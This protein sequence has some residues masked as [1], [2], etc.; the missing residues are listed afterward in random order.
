MRRRED[1][2]F[3]DTIALIVDSLGSLGKLDKHAFLKQVFEAA[4]ELIPEAQKGSLYELQGEMFRPV[5][6]RGYDFAVL[7]RISF[8]RD[9]AFI[10][11]DV[12]SGSSVV[13]R[14][15][16]IAARDPAAFPRETLEAFAELGTLSG[17]TSLYA[18]ICVEG[19]VAGLISLD[20]FDD[21]GFQ[22]LSRK[23]LQYY[24]RLISQFYAQ[25]LLQERETRR[26]KDIVSSLVS[27]I[28]VM[29][30]HTEGHAQRV[31][32]Y[33]VA[34]ARGLGLGEEEVEEIG[35]AALLHDIGKLGIPTQILRKPG[36]LS[37]EEYEQVKLHPGDG[38]RILSSIEGFE[39]IAEMAYHHH[40]RYD[41]KGYPEGLSGEEI[42]LG[43]QLIGLADAF[44]AMTSERAYRP[45]MTVEAALDVIR[46][47]SGAQFGPRAAA[48]ALGVIADLADRR[49]ELQLQAR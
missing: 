40:E 15:T 18:P 39:R 25:K 6:S 41:G 46:E 19:Q 49:R 22:G 35:T 45:A 10:D 20:K 43:A 48:V 2:R 42:S 21:T 12:G 36:R 13:A 24:A 32:D 30:S 31:R 44:D 37:A 14:E 27:A 16:R 38:Y 4:F 34:L 29:D 9:E 28:Q 7:S 5:F 8:G 17:F 26:Y 3:Y 47:E 23:I 1:D 11:F 33:S